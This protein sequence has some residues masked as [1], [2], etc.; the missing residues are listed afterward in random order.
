MIF[1]KKS[2]NKF[3]VNVGFESKTRLPLS[4]EYRNK[5]LEEFIEYE[6]KGKSRLASLA[7]SWTIDDFD[8]EVQNF[9]FKVDYYWNCVEDLKEVSNDIMELWKELFLI[10]DKIN[11]ISTF[12]LYLGTLAALTSEAGF[13]QEL[14]SDLD[15]RLTTLVYNSFKEEL[16]SKE[17]KTV[18]NKII[19]WFNFKINVYYRDLKLGV[20]ER[21]VKFL[22]ELYEAYE[23]DFE[24][25]KTEL[26][27]VFLRYF[28]S[29]DYYYRNLPRITD[30]NYYQFYNRVLLGAISSSRNSNDFKRMSDL[31]YIYHREKKGRSKGK[32]RRIG[33]NILDYCTGY[34]EKPYRLIFFY[35]SLQ[36][37]FLFINFPYEGSVLQ[38]KGLNST[39]KFLEKFIGTIYFN[40]TTMLTSVYGDISPLNALSR[41]V[42]VIQQLLG[43]IVSASYVTL[44]L[45]KLFRF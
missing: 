7:Y 11:D 3:K 45:R 22:Q 28:N 14:K 27:S 15:N 32:I 21:E 24:K 5:T 39:E 19:N 13:K 38:F 33:S 36:V 35:I 31:I 12:E 29:V 26:P 37:I 16:Y 18:L 17:L 1:T 40:S 10:F 23:T 43:F 4:D 20:A 25:L 30:Y 8:Q 42:I 2:Q 9:E 41:L 34:G 44:L 6:T